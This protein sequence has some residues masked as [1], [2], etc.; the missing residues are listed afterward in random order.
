MNWMA[1]MLAENTMGLGSCHVPNRRVQTVSGAFSNQLVRGGD[2]D[3]FSDRDRNPFDIRSK[4][5]C[6]REK[7]FQLLPCLIPV[8]RVV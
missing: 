2:Q 7:S 6:S 1:D 8:E 3:A 4:S 5:L